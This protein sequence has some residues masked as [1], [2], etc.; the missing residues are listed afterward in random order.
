MFRP[1][2]SLLY[3]GLFIAFVPVSAA[4][5]SAEEGKAT[6]EDKSAAKTL[7]ELVKDGPAFFWLISATRT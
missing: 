3:T 6:E 5:V 7:K 2:S 4:T 1:I